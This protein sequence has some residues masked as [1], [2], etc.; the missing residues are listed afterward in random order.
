MFLC[1]F[2]LFRGDVTGGSLVIAAL[3]LFL[4]V[5]LLVAASEDIGDARQQRATTQDH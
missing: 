2:P 3:A 5:G 4:V 1:P